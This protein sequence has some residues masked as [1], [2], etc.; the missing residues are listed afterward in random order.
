MARFTPAGT[1]ITQQTG[2]FRT[3]LDKEDAERKRLAKIRKQRRGLE[4]ERAVVQTETA[5]PESK[6]V[7]YEKRVGIAEEEFERIRA[8][9]VTTEKPVIPATEVG[10]EQ[11]RVAGMSEELYLKTEKEKFQRTLSKTAT[12]YE[13]RVFP[14]TPV[15]E[16]PAITRFTPSEEVHTQ[17]I[18]IVQGIVSYKQ[19]TPEEL[20]KKGI[21]ALEYQ[22]LQ[23]TA[24]SGGKRGT[25]EAS[26]QT[27]TNLGFSASSY[28]SLAE[29][30][31]AA[32]IARRARA[33]E[34]SPR[35]KRV[36]EA[37][38][39]RTEEILRREQKTSRKQWKEEQETRAVTEQETKIAAQQAL[40]EERYLRTDILK[41]KQEQI[42]EQRDLTRKTLGLPEL[43]M[44]A[45]TLPEAIDQIPI[46]K[47][48]EIIAQISD[49]KDKVVV[50][51]AI[52][53]QQRPNEM[54]LDAVANAGIDS[55]LLTIRG[56]V[57]W[58]Q[59]SEAKDVKDRVRD[60]V[61]SGLGL[62]HAYEDIASGL[63][64][65]YPAGIEGNDEK[66]VRAMAYA[67]AEGKAITQ[68]LADQAYINR[69]KQLASDTV[70]Y[71]GQFGIAV[72]RLDYLMDMAKTRSK[73]E[74][75]IPTGESLLQNTVLNGGKLNNEQALNFVEDLL[76]QISPEDKGY[77]KFVVDVID[78][79]KE[80]KSAL[81]EN[82]EAFIDI[83]VNGVI[84]KASK[85]KIEEDKAKA[86]VATAF[87][88]K[89][90]YRISPESL[91]VADEN[92]GDG[93]K[94]WFVGI[95]AEKQTEIYHNLSPKGQ[96]N[97]RQTVFGRRNAVDVPGHG[98][99]M[100]APTP[101]YATPI[102]EFADNQGYSWK[103][104]DEN[105][106][107]KPEYFRIALGALYNP[108][109]SMATKDELLDKLN[110][111][112]KAYLEVTPHGDHLTVS[113]MLEGAE[114]IVFNETGDLELFTGKRETYPLFDVA[115][116]TLNKKDQALLQAKYNALNPY[117]EQLFK[118]AFIDLR[119]ADV[120]T[121]ALWEE[122]QILRDG[123]LLGKEGRSFSKKLKADFEEQIEL[124][125][126]FVA[127][128][129]AEA[130][131]W[132]VFTGHKGD[133]ATDRRI[134]YLGYLGARDVYHRQQNRIQRD[135]T[136]EL[137]Q[138]YVIPRALETERNPTIAE[139]YEGKQADIQGVLDN[140]LPVIRSEIL[141]VDDELE[142]ISPT[143][144]VKIMRELAGIIKEASSTEFTSIATGIEIP[145]PLPTL[146]D[147]ANKVQSAY[148]TLIKLYGVYEDNINSLAEMETSI[149][150]RMTLGIP[151]NNINEYKEVVTPFTEMR[152]IHDEIQ[153]AIMR[154]FGRKVLPAFALPEQIREIRQLIKDYKSLPAG[155]TGEVKERSRRAISDYLRRYDE[156]IWPH[157]VMREVPGV[158]MSGLKKVVTGVG[159]IT[160]P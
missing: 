39:A 157:E 13:T 11:A 62:N 109:V 6:E 119:I 117:D 95:G 118:T 125:D 60:I 88:S 19:P 63:R 37:D 107:I 61:D 116:K 123:I 151:I 70:K 112:L 78:Q 120:P 26:Q 145:H 124:L 103:W 105:N 4:A 158:I 18:N 15:A 93:R 138:S 130:K 147:R 102:G 98:V 17:A 146:E 29:G 85:I 79:Y 47:E 31:K 136:N 131:E 140:L 110:S 115:L 149:E 5:L 8:G 97:L 152:E 96:L 1:N 77:Q 114:S 57:S 141:G 127:E 74:F 121:T 99:V 154:N 90:N 75:Q 66:F 122:T 108:N 20:Q 132:E 44:T 160:R 45:E 65:K 155:I 24:R 83:A 33:G 106:L 25:A 101:E 156:A 12:P 56:D 21:S 89:T 135:E 94:L 38:V 82:V 48:E 43:Q 58:Q 69:Q 40:T 148:Q 133:T 50:A 76:L 81:P 46:G 71:S 64:S 32:D 23:K 49:M 159:Q 100:Y 134:R 86:E 51:D 36:Y 92:I 153:T 113:T 128:G 9:E 53:E 54:F 68:E 137:K 10:R 104:Y 80:G 150:N 52:E 142:T 2:S 30:G 27:L 7:P 41:T 111:S 34:L 73:G 59:S 72:N 3:Y 84:D 87:A 22:N 126:E 35:E 42:K 139:T 67:N 28:L 143:T 91:I 14:T 129:S 144:S 55:K 16:A